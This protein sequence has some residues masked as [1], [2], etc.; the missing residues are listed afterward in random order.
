MNEQIVFYS[1]QT[2]LANYINTT[3]YKNTHYIWCSP[4][5]D[6]DKVAY[7]SNPY[8]IY[9][10]LC[11]EVN[12]DDDHYYRPY[13]RQN[14]AGLKKGVKAKLKAGVITPEIADE[15]NGLI[16]VTLKKKDYQR[17]FPLIYI[18]PKDK[19]LSKIEV[20]P[21]KER[22]TIVSNEYRVVELD[23]TDFDI[24]DMRKL[25]KGII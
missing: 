8:Y 23:G 7:T 24:I 25:K 22:A 21:P 9:K 11:K 10:E 14:A 17:F 19:V 3:Y 1:T 18:I 2:V 12:I 6:P 13:I 20:V 15:I 4:T 16:G 5:C